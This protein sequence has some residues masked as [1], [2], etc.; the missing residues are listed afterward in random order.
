MKDPFH[1]QWH[2][3]NLCNLRCEHCYQDDFSKKRDLDWS[4]L[5][6]ISDNLLNTIKEW[7][8]KACIHVTG[9]EPLLRPELF[10]LLDHL[11][12]QSEV[13]E[14]GIITNGLLMDRER[15][16]KLSDFPKL[17]KIKISLDGADAETNDAIRSKGAF[18][19]VMQNLSLIRREK[20]FEIILMFTVMKKN[21]RN[22]PFF[23][24]LCQDNGIDGLIIERFIPLGKGRGITSEVLRKEEWNEMIGMLFHFF[25][26]EGEQN[27][28]LPYQAFQISF[29]GEEPELLG[30]PCVIGVDGL[31]IM[32]GGSVFPCRRLPISI[33]NLL[34]TPLKEIWEKSEIL[35]KLRRKES[36]K[37]K[38]GRCEMKECR[39]CRS[40]AFALTGDCLGED[41]H[42]RYGDV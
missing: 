23:F 14:L 15:M 19:K 28:V 13:E 2:I 31:C 29:T 25:L 33:G 36:L 22:L 7:D 10:H 37:G 34:E 18:E 32:P 3:T 16:I 17:K 9:G 40:L 35:E 5:K 42:C 6:K 38:C 12:Q 30:A 24:K 41:P 4:E 8:Q 11:D 26:T 20:R 1:F 39:G 21:F 27:S